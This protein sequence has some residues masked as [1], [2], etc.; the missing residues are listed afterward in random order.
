AVT[1]AGT[2]FANND[3]CVRMIDAGITFE[4]AAAG[5]PFLR[6][7][8][9]RSLRSLDQKMIKRFAGRTGSNV[10]DKGEYDSQG[11]AS[12]DLDE[13]A[14]ALVRYQVDHYHN[15]PHA[16]LRGESPRACWLRLTEQFGVMAVALLAVVVA[17]RSSGR[18]GSSY[19]GRALE[20]GSCRYGR[21]ERHRIGPRATLSRSW[22]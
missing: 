11:R 9:E 15:T 7:T 17:R 14:T 19:G 10:K 6:G 2:S 21:G 3:F 18:P 1:D 22:P 13:L 16:G 12:L 8:V 20:A 5:V 4:I